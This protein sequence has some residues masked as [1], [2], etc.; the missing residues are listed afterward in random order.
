MFGVVSGCHVTRDPT[1]GGI[2]PLSLPLA[3]GLDKD[4]DG[5]AATLEKDK[6]K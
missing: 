6:N 5:E 2:I 3:T 1:W 4:V